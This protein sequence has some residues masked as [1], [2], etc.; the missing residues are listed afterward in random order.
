MQPAAGHI[1]DKDRLPK[2]AGG[3]VSKLLNFHNYFFVFF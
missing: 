2:K 1:S 3:L